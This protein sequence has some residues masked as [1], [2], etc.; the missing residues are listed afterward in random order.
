MLKEIKAKHLELRKSAK[1][2]LTGDLTVQK[3]VLT[4]LIGELEGIAK[5]KDLDDTLVL[6]VIN[7]FL[8][9]N[10]ETQMHTTDEVVA[11]GLFLENQILESFL[12][13]QLSEAELSMA[14]KGIINKFVES[15]E[16]F[17]I[18]QIMGALKA[19][20]GGQYDGRMASTMVKEQLGGK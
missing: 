7:K 9:G 13:K 16:V 18:G 3:M 19:E 4:T 10:R 1:G 8:K 15:G 2:D 12:P 14:V 17:S 11:R 5:K 20:Y 6:Q